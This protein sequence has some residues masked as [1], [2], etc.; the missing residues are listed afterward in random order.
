MLKWFKK[1]LI[2]AL[3]N[4]FVKIFPMGDGSFLTLG[5]WYWTRKEGTWM[6][7]YVVDMKEVDRILKDDILKQ[8]AKKPKRRSF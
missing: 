3:T 8:E 4:V 6:S 2:S 1:V 7:Q 5:K